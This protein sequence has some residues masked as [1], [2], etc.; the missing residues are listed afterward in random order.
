MARQYIA[1]RDRW[2]E[3]GAAQVS[4]GVDHRRDNEADD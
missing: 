2:L 1:Q 4:S 3:M